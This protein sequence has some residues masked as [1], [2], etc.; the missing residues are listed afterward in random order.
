MAGGAFIPTG[1][2]EV[3]LPFGKRMERITVDLLKDATRDRRF[4]V[5]SDNVLQ[6]LD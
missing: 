4:N 5:G 6:R 3:L 1:K 2:L